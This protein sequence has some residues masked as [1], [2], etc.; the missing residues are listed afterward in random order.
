MAKSQVKLII[1]PQDKLHFPSLIEIW[2][3]KDLLMILSWRDIKVRYKQTILGVMWVVLQ[4]L[5]T[6]VVFSYF[7][8]KVAKISSNNLPYSLFVLIGLVF[9]NFFSGTLTQASNSLVENEQII[10]KVYFPRYLL[11]LSTAIT[12]TIDLGVNLIMLGIYSVVISTTPN[13]KLVWLIVP[14]YILTSFSAI[15]L[16]WFFSAIN[17][18]Y[19]DVRYAL[20]FL[21]QVLL[22]LSPIIYPLN[23]VSSANGLILAINPL[24][25]AVGLMRYAFDQSVAVAPLH[26]AISIFSCVVMVC[27]GGWYF[28]KSEKLFADIA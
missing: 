4:P 3:Y 9:W 16:G 20:P 14:A 28:M 13:I 21:F 18:K 1:L 25:T 7:F 17:I 10:K 23:I 8:G 12:S 22:F 19:R 27:I 2:R 11:P 15:G 24:T 6:M 26:M 5:M